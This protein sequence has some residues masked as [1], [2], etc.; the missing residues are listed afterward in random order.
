MIFDLKNKFGMR[1]YTPTNTISDPHLLFATGLLTKQFLRTL[2]IS[3][4]FE[5]ES[6]IITS[7]QVDFFEAYAYQNLIN[8]PPHNCFFTCGDSLNIS[9]AVRL[10][11]SLTSL[12][13]L[14]VGT[15]CTSICT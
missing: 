4:F 5:L 12:V 15:L 3:C 11:I 13:M 10:L 14:Y 9:L 6:L 2:V 7:C 1:E 8:Y